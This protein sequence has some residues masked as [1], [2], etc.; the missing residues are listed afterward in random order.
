MICLTVLLTHQTTHRI[1]QF[2]KDPIADYVSLDANLKTDS[3]LEMMDTLTFADQGA[4][5]QELVTVNDEINQ[6]KNAYHGPHNKRI[7][8]IISLK[9]QGYSNEE[10]AK[11]L[12]TSAK[13]IRAVFYRLRNRLNRKKSKKIN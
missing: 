3:D 8:L 11:R 13:A 5:P 2:K 10:I 1:S 4:S 12:K 6:F 7:Q 9:Q